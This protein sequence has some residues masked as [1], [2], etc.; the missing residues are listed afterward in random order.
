MDANMDNSYCSTEN[1][2]LNDSGKHEVERNTEKK[3]LNT[4]KIEHIILAG[5]GYNGLLELGVLDYAMSNNILDI[6]NVKTIYGTSVGSLIGLLLS[7]S[8]NIKDIIDFFVN[9][10]W[11]KMIQFDVSKLFNIQ[12]YNGIFDKS[13]IEGIIT[14]FLHSID[15]SPN[16]TMK[17]HFEITGKELHVIS[18]DMNEMERVSLNYKT[19]PDIKM[20]D[21][22]YASCCIPIVLKPLLYKNYVF[23]DGGVL[24]NYPIDLCIEE[25]D[26]SLNSLGITFN[27]S[28]YNVVIRENSTITE[29]TNKLY[30]CISNKLQIQNKLSATYSIELDADNMNFNDSLE[31]IYS[32]EKRL[33]YV[34]KGFHI[35]ENFF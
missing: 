1:L 10:P 12:N 5:G 31:L 33:E 20:I 4:P 26:C 34:E 15:V 22:I 28:N 18:C 3:A 11:H 30:K 2:L 16:I 9:K 6:D 8:I 23:V 24:N 25:Q 35:G 17:E 13:F 19:F 21:A 32:K 7:L 29:F 27:R 14:P